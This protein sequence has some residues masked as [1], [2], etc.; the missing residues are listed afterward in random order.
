MGA[1]RR[2]ACMGATEA[3]REDHRLAWRL[4][5]LIVACCERLEAGGDVPLED[6]EAISS[7]I[8]GFL[9]AVHHAREENTY[10]ACVGAYGMA[11]EIRAFL[12][13]HEFA[14]RVAAKVA[15]HAA[16]WRAG[17]DAREPVCRF[18]RAYATFLR[19][20]MTKEEAFFDDAEEALSAEEEAEM[21]DYFAA[22]SADAGAARH[23][24]EAIAALEA[25]PWTRA[26]A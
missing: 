2:A 23:A 15:R 10:F 13:E 14:R 1:S 21:R 7:V 4:E 12:I 3:L 24:E 8:D 18:L 17:E 6:I 20:H 16:R 9:D 26:G 11:S 19:D 5:A 22:A 25:A